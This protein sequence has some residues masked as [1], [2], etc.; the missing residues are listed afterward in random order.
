[1]KISFSVLG[2]EIFSVS[3]ECT[4]LVLIEEGEEDAQHL[5]Y[6]FSSDN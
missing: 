6:G 2:V 4:D 3:S 5:P 1:M